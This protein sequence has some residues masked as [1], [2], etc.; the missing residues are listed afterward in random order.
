M[1]YDHRTCNHSKAE[2]VRIDPD[3]TQVTTN[4]VEGFWGNFKVALR[5]RRGT[6]RF[7]LERFA[8]VRSWRTLG[9]TVFGVVA[10]L[11]QEDNV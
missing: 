8:R 4:G 11:T 6:R 2:Y 1:G 3:L 10:K 7:N 5:N 9:E